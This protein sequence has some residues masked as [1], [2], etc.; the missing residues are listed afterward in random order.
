MKLNSKTNV[1]VLCIT[2]FV[3]FCMLSYT[4]AQIITTVAGAGTAGSSGDVGPATNAEIAPR[5]ITFNNVNNLYVSDFLGNSVRVINASDTINTIAG[6]GTMGYSG[7]GGA[8]TAAA[9]HY[10]VNVL[11]DAAGNIV[12]ADGQNHCIR[13][14]SPTGIIT[15]IAGNGTPGCSGDGGPASAAQLSIPAGLAIDAAGNIYVVNGGCHSVRKINTSGIIT[16]IAGSG[17]WGFSGDGGPATAAQL[18][19]PLGITFDAIGNMFISDYLNCRIRKIDPAGSITTYA[20]SSTA[21]GF[22]GD[23]GAATAALLRRPEGI[24]M[25]AAGNLIIADELN[26]RIRKV[27]PLG[28]ITTIAGSSS[29]GGYGGDGGPATSTLL[30]RPADVA[31]DCAGNL[32]IADAYN[33]RVRT[34]TYNH[35][36]YI[37][38]GLA[39]TLIVCADTPFKPIDGL[40]AA[41]ELDAGQTITWSIGMPPAHGVV[42]GTY[43]ATSTGGTIMPVGLTYTPTAGYTGA[44]SFR[45]KVSDCKESYATTIYVTVVE[46]L[47]ATPRGVSSVKEV[48]EVFPNPNKGTLIVQLSSPVDG[49]ADVTITNVLNQKIKSF[50]TKTNIATDVSLHSPTGIYFINVFTPSGRYIAKITVD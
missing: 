29:T 3:F 32:Y 6:N 4:N 7:D 42:S 49:E 21:G 50:K 30:N 8:A 26:H 40:L 2:L 41:T 45:I 13:K 37:A 33:Y 27:D 9:L 43:S 31:F 14:V 39:Q 1:R 47:L 38:G 24:T 35:S 11:F 16:T 18:N 36:P 34:I 22:G 15:T 19:N 23:G 20:G 10:P 25:D 46:C 17:V 5:S 12:I 28:I 48:L 44:D